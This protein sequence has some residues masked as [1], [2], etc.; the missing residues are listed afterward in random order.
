MNQSHIDDSHIDDFTLNEFLDDALAAAQQR[1]VAAHLLACAECRTRMAELRS[2]FTR[3]ESLV[4]QDLLETAPSPNFAANVVAAL[5]PRPQQSPPFPWQALAVQ[6]TVALGLLT[7]LGSVLSQSMTRWLL[8]AALRWQEIQAS[9]LWSLWSADLAQRGSD[10]WL[11]VQRQMAD[12]VALLPQPTLPAFSL[13]LALWLTVLALSC[14]LW[15]AATR[16]VMMTN[17][18]YHLEKDHE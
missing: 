13:S 10:L 1:Q 6:L 18:F 11:V 3:F 8:P 7:L 17:G 4:A 9:D 5:A 2:L 14:L 16:W 15:L 12:G